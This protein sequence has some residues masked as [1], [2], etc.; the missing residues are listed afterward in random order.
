MSGKLKILKRLL[1][2]SLAAFFTAL[3]VGAAESETYDPVPYKTYTYWQ[4]YK[5]K[6]AVPIKAIY[7]FSENIDA[8]RLGISGNFS[9]TYFCFG[10]DGLLYAL[11]SQNNKIL[12]LDKEY[13]LKRTVAGLYDSSGNAVELKGAEGLFITK[14]G[15]IYIA[16]TQNNRIIVTDAGGKIIRTVQKPESE[17]IPEDV[18]FLPKRILQD[19]QGFI[20]VLSDGSYYGM[21]LYSEDRSFLGF[22]GAN[23]VKNTVTQFIAKMWKKLTSTNAKRSA[24][25]SRLPYQFTDLYADKD[26]FIY[27]ATGKT[28]Q[29]L[30][31]G[32]IRQ[33]SPGG[34]NIL[35]SEDTTFGDYYVGTVDNKQLTPNIAG[36][37]VD[38]S[39]FI[40]CYD[41]SYGRI[42]LYDRDLFM[43]AAF[44]GGAGKGDQK[45]TFSGIAGIDLLD[46]GDRIV[47][48][49][50]H[51][52][53]IT[54]FSVT[55]Y[56]KLLKEADKLDINGDYDKTGELCRKILDCDSGNISAYYILAKSAMQEKDYKAA[57]EYSKKGMSKKL[58]SQ[59]FDYLRKDWLKANF[60]WLLTLLA[61]LIAAVAAVCVYAKKR[62]LVLIKNNEIKSVIRAPMHPAVVFGDIKRGKCGSVIAGTVVMAAFYITMI[63][64]TTSSGFLFR[65]LSE[66]SINSLLVFA[67]TIGFVILWSVTN[68]A[69][70]TLFGGIGKLREIYLVI[71]YS[72]F[73]V[74]IGN[75][76]YIVFSHMLNLTEGEF[77]TIFLVFTELL[78]VFM[79]IVGSVIIH[80]IS[81][82][83]FVG[84]A[85]MT[86]LGMLIVIF[87][88]ILTVLLLQQ[89]VSFVGTI[90]REIF[91][92]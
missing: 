56:G 19:E 73:P 53:D 74:V 32:Q 24:S 1:C 36:I 60:N 5:E 45:G 83:R 50:S 55:E 40:Y 38:D 79:V 48:I 29:T 13:R 51:D 61:G 82:G 2:V 49:D 47:A 91:F 87:I 68:W 17:L 28:S 10:G 70:A 80:D 71:T 6:K 33:L 22:Y 30:Q 59:A 90:I 72:L 69:I 66:N 42:Y 3:T 64:K 8:E 41:I 20:Y 89:A 75:T 31:T 92:R 35:D 63:L 25:A 44:G 7:G 67:R 26:N 12:V 4:G 15:K 23:S 46:G 37:A 58:Y 34:A 84:I 16:D 65:P 81:F 76:V 78:A 57:L 21:I 11:D 52:L 86:I 14:D 9:V 43:L 54:V 88:G 39:G 85:V 27:T 77:L 62:R 18:I